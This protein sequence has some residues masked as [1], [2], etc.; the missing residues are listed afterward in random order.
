MIIVGAKIRI[1]FIVLIVNINNAFGQKNSDSFEIEGIISPSVT[2]TDSIYLESAFIN[3]ELYET[4]AFS[5]KVKDGKFHFSGNINYPIGLFLSFQ[6]NDKNFVLSQMIFIDRGTHQLSINDFKYNNYYL[7]ENSPINA[8]FKNKFLP[9]YKKIL[10]AEELSVSNENVIKETDYKSIRKDYN[11]RKIL[12]ILKYAKKYPNSFI[13]LWFAIERYSV[14]GYDDNLLKIYNLLSKNIKQ[15]DTAK[16]FA[17]MLN[18]KY[19]ENKIMDLPVK[20]QNNEFIKYKLTEKFTLVDFWFSNCV[21]CLIEFPKYKGI[22]DKYRSKGFDIIAIST[23]RTEEVEHWKK[24]VKEKEL[25]WQN[26]LDENGVQSKKININKF[27][28][29]FLL[30][31]NGKIIKKDIS[32]EELKL[33]L[34]NNLNQ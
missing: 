28:T 15:T 13:S 32:A 2:K 24:A 16:K 12:Y 27:P 30:D 9:D 14:W 29:N 31:S 18:E 1:L 25:I 26:Y 7:L 19:F 34:D 33:F 22:Y 23:D 17:R 11:N 10:A 5:S 21:P 20:D 3:S 8:E 6:N 4:N